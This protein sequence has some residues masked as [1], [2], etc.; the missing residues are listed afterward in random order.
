MILQFRSTA[1]SPLILTPSKHDRFCSQPSTELKFKNPNL[2]LLELCTSMDELKQL[3]AQLILSGHAHQTLPL[4]RLIAFTALHPHG[5]LGYARL[6]FDR[7]SEDPNIFIWST[8]IRAYSNSTFPELGIEFYVLMLQNGVVPE[9]FTIPFVLNAC[10]EVSAGKEGRMVHGQ[11]LKLGLYSNEFVQNGLVKLYLS[12][13]DFGSAHLLFDG[14]SEPSE[15]AWNMLIDGYGK[16]GEVE[17]AHQ[18]FVKMPQS[19]IIAMNSILAAYVRL[20][21]LDV[22]QML[23]DDMP[24]RDITSWNTLIDGYFLNGEFK[25]ALEVFHHM[26]MEKIKPD[27]VTLAL[28]LSS[29]G[30]L[31]AIEQGRWIHNYIKVNEMEI[32]V[33]IGTSLIHMYAKSGF[34]E[35]AY[36]VFNEMS[37]RDALVWNVM[38]GSLA[39]HGLAAQSLDL[40]AR[41]DLEGV[42][43]NELTFLG[44]LSACSHVGLVSEGLKQ[45][46]SMTG[47]YNIEATDKHYACMV[48]LF[49]RAGMFEEATEF[50]DRMPR[51]PNPSVWGALL[52]ACKIHGK[53]ELGAAAGKHL[54]ELDPQ[55]DGRYVLVS[56]LYAASGNWTKA[57]EI[58]RLMM[59]KGIKKTPGCSLIEVDGFVHEFLVGDRNHPR[60]EEIYSMMA[61]L[62]K[63]MK[64]LGR[65]DE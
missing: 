62:T 45:F 51:K 27:K 17:F 1:T 10:A 40:F 60:T 64:S 4:S 38:I 30:E 33:Y 11:A 41:M 13:G 20:G 50:I 59:Q 18:L 48:D 35:Y 34:I 6:L 31:G 23:F 56:N 12:A 44:V 63:E 65:K 2:S 29:C 26:L 42:V 52:S 61:M 8:M 36:K 37:K 19:G 28:V 24:R 25:K 54:I 46:N 21:D 55:G 39:M 57:S 9:N 43:P 16:I 5:D 7:R 47:D 15:V 32:N 22:A 49:G 53:K 14:F 3:H 58:R